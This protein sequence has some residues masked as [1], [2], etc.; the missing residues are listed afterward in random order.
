MAVSGAPSSAIGSFAVGVSPIGA[1][2]P[3]SGP[4]YPRSV[5]G[6]GAIGSLAIGVSPIGTSPA[7]DP[8]ATIISQYANSPVLTAL[9]ISFFEALDQTENLDLF[10]DLIWNV[11]TAQGY[12]LDVWGRIVGVGRTL[13]VSSVEYFGFDQQLPGVGTFGPQDVSP[14]FSGQPTTSNFSL[15]DAAYRQLILAKAAF[16][17]TDGSIHAINALLMAL[18]P[19]EGQAYVTDNGGM[20]MTYTFS[21]NLS[22]LEQAIVFQ[23][24]VLPKPCGVTA[25]VVAAS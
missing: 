21:W 15:T 19:G 5:P 8:W 9:I 12:G 1:T 23:S 11:D 22:P 17:I 24:G 16:N 4:P 10:F 2:R 18:F 13:R 7:F 25:N 14:F 6:S 3:E 20:S